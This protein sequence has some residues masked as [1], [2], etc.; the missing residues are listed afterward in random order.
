MSTIDTDPLSLAEI[1]KIDEELEGHWKVFYSALFVTG[2]RVGE[3]LAIRRRDF[4]LTDGGACA[5]IMVDRL[6]RRRDMPADR[7]P[8]PEEIGAAIASITPPE[9]MAFTWHKRS[10]TGKTLDRF[11]PLTQRAA[12]KALK[13]AAQA[14]GVRLDPETE[15]T[16]AHPHLYRHAFGRAAARALSARGRGDI[17]VRTTIQRM[18]GHASFATSAVY[19]KQSADEV[20]STWRELQA[21]LVPSSKKQI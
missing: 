9:A 8:L 10:R 12:L 14:A 16:T 18:F 17:E 4:I 3:L 5:G 13:K 15:E 2:L 1:R 11:S 20:E 6:K 21:E 19:L 7:C